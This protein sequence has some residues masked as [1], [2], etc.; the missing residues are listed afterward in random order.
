[1]RP[2]CPQA[3]AFLAALCN[4]GDERNWD[5]AVT[6]LLTRGGLV[7]KCASLVAEKRLED[8]VQSP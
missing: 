2:T 7:N 5:W 6:P 3:Y 1:M 8:L 4:V